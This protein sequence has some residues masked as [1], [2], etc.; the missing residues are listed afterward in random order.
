ML[1]LEPSLQKKMSSPNKGNGSASLASCARTGRQVEEE[2]MIKHEASQRM[3]LTALEAGVLTPETKAVVDRKFSLTVADMITPGFDFT[4]SLELRRPPSSINA[5]KRY[6]N[7]KTAL[8]KNGSLMNAWHN[9]RT[10]YLETLGK[11]VREFG[12]IYT[13][14]FIHRHGL[15]RIDTNGRTSL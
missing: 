4:Q 10:P 13:G 5:R 3:M 8:V 1:L 11:E 2:A 9:S 7:A 6:E 14:I 15:D 12:K